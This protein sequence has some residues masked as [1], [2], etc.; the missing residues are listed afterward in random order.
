MAHLKNSE[1]FWVRLTFFF[2]SNSESKTICEG[3]RNKIFKLHSSPINNENRKTNCWLYAKK[4]WNTFSLLE[5]SHWIVLLYFGHRN[6]SIMIT[7]RKALS[8]MSR[9]NNFLYFLHS[10]NGAKRQKEWYKEHVGFKVRCASF[11]VL[12][13]FEKYLQQSGLESW[14]Y[15]ME[16]SALGSSDFT[17]HTNVRYTPKPQTISCTGNEQ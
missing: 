17:N 16:E 8:N 15:E 9:S 1:I 2:H 6:F 5:F 10:T 4:R 14:A 11:R 12:S 13:I 7:S 3:K